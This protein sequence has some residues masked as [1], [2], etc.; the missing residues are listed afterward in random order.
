MKKLKNP[1]LIDLVGT[2]STQI[3]DRIKNICVLCNSDSQK[4]AML[5]DY[6]LKNRDKKMMIFTETKDEAKQF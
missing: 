3:P 1:L 2:D 6:I 5:R 4:H